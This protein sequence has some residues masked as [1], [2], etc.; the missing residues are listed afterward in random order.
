MEQIFTL[1]GAELDD[2]MGKAKPLEV[3]D[4]TAAEV[5]TRTVENTARES[6]QAD[7]KKSA[8]PLAK[9]DKSSS[10]TI[11]VRE[12][13]SNMDATVRMAGALSIC[14]A[15][16]RDAQKE[17]FARI[18]AGAELGLPPMAAIRMVHFIKGRASLSADAMVAV[19]KARGVKFDVVHSNPPGTFCQV[20]AER[21]G[22]EYSFRWTL[23]MAKNAGLSGANWKSYPWDMLYARAAS[24]VCRK[25]APDVIGGIY[26][27]EELEEADE[28]SGVSNLQAKLN[29][30]EAK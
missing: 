9:L 4:T 27:P 23:D 1:T 22:T 19:C 16:S 8:Q 18:V 14:I 5:H 21:D 30:L 17:A 20:S 6:V 12:I 26:A 13:F 29:N 2:A 11:T 28:P 15:D 24:H 3:I 10:N 7:T 25:I